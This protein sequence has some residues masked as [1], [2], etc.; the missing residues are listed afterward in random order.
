MPKQQ[1][2]HFVI[3]SILSSGL[4]ILTM[5]MVFRFTWKTYQK[6]YDHIK[7]WAQNPELEPLPGL[8]GKFVMSQIKKIL[9]KQYKEFPQIGDLL[10]A[11]VTGKMF[12]VTFRHQPEPIGPHGYI[13][14]QRM[15]E[16]HHEL[17]RVSV[18]D[19]YPSSYEKITP[20]AE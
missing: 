11:K 20:N 18:R 5:E 12:I 10:R 2:L 3:L 15:D 9:R 8:Y 1:I 19:Y 7:E 6:A 4:T 14:I 13:D 16:G 17:I